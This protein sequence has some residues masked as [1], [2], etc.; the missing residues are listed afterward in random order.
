MWKT[1]RE[2]RSP[3]GF[4]RL[5]MRQGTDSS[6]QEFSQSPVQKTFMPP[7]QFPRNLWKKSVE[8]WKCRRD[9]P[10]YLAML[11]DLNW[12]SQRKTSTSSQSTGSRTM[13]SSSSWAQSLS[14]RKSTPCFWWN[15]RSWTPSWRK[16]CILDEFALPN[17]LWQLQY[18]SSRRR[19]AH[20]SWSRTTECSILWWSRISTLFHWSP[21]SYHNSVER[22]TSPS[23]MS[24]GVLT[25]F[26]LNPEMS[27]RRPSRP[28]EAYS[29]LW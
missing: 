7:L 16:T 23:W 8:P 15:K 18:S 3:S 17:L 10:S 11:K 21:N 27:G 2:T 19:M 29:N 14:H 26:V 4:A 1:W 22:D 12:C 24:I 28:I 6:W 13:L 20:S 9:F 25:M 5:N